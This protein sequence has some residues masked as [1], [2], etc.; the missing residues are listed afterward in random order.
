MLSVYIMGGLGNQLFQIF[1]LISSALDYKTEFI[2]PYYETTSGGI[3]RHTYW[4][5]FM[6]NIKKYTG[7]LN[8]RIAIYKEA[9]FNYKPLV[10]NISKD[11]ILMY[12]GYFQSEKYFINNYD[13]ITKLLELEQIHRSIKENWAKDHLDSSKTNISMHFRLGDYKNIQDCH[14]IITDTYYINSLK[15]DLHRAKYLTQYLYH[16]LYR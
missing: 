5:S 8:N 16:L 4:N 9:G 12:H 3:K 14:P 6:K 15:Y 2:I 11:T 13:S 1:A 10:S 7:N